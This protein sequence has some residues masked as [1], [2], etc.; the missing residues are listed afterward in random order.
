MDYSLFQGELPIIIDQE[1]EVSSFVMGY[2]YHCKTWVPFVGED[3]QCRMEPDNVVDKYAVA[4][5]NKD[6]VAG[7]LMKGK[8]GNLAKTV[9]LFLRTDTINSA[10]VEITGKA[11][12]KGI[13]MGMQVPCKFIV[14]GSKPVLDKLKDMFQQLQ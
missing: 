6:R 13:G 11:V 8:S 4:V 5:I 3:L 1:Y 14:T 2:H 10:R 9:F 7:H 12:N